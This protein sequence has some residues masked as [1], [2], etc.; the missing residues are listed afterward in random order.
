MDKL[1][2]AFEQV[3][4]MLYGRLHDVQRKQIVERLHIPG[5][6]LLRPREAQNDNAAARERTNHLSCV[7][8]VHT[9]SPVALDTVKC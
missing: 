8:D 1:D 9:Y 6:P 5:A 4:Q 2:S 7:A 3:K